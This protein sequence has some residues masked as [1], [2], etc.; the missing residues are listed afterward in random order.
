ME[1]KAIIRTL[2]ML[3][4]RYAKKPNAEA[5][6]KSI[7]TFV[8]KNGG[9]L[10]VIADL[11]EAGE[12]E[13][14][15]YVRN[16]LGMVKVQAEE[17]KTIEV[18]ADE[19]D[20][21]KPLKKAGRPKK[22]EEYARDKEG[23]L[24]IID[25]VKKT[26]RRVL[27]SFEQLADEMLDFPEMSLQTYVRYL[28]DRFPDETCTFKK[29]KLHFRGYRISLTAEEGFVVE[30][31]T[32]RYEVVD[33]PWEGIPTPKELGEWFV[34]PVTRELTEA[35]KL[36][37]HLAA[38]ERGKKLAYDKRR[39]HE[40]RAA[41]I[42]KAF[43]EA[44][45]IDY[46]KLRKQ[47]LKKIKDIRAKIDT[48]TCPTD[49][50]S[51]IPFKRWRRKANSLLTKWKKKEIRYAK[52]L[53]E[54]EKIT[55][56]ETFVIEEKRHRS[57]FTGT[58]MPAHEKVGYLR[59]NKLEVDDKLV[60]AVPFLV[61]Y[62]LYHEKRAMSQLMKYGS[63]EITARELIEN[64]MEVDWKVEYKK[65]AIANTAENARVI[66]CVYEACGIVAPQDLL[67]ETD[68]K[69]GDVI[70]LYV[71]GEFKRRTIAK[72]TKGVE[73]GKEVGILKTDKWI[74]APVKE[75]K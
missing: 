10:N 31:T 40:K 22:E 70:L 14:K 19:V 67:F 52:F 26:C 72:V 59:G 44:E 35:E 21:E 73:V 24:Y 30:D 28:K 75:K 62:L 65:N 58:L 25:S 56:E 45:D 46:E 33:T 42:D 1:I 32:K 16:I 13:L 43:E 63:G 20:F 38:V 57:A 68:L 6:K 66:T 36:Q 2:K 3:R 41:E 69:V 9:R 49:F 27:K 5:E 60:D 39:Q 51:M 17:D 47:V 37:E 23:N 34:K 18:N 11:N 15:S 12:T 61:E 54:L 7:E 4:G 8:E 50:P 53:N 29:G 48:A 71:D 55:E 74:M 64:P